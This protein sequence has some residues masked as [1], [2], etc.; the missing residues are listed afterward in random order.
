MFGR[1]DFYRWLE[2]VTA[3]ELMLWLTYLDMEAKGTLDYLPAE[4]LAQTFKNLWGSRADT[5]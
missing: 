1:A 3:E 5:N 2:E 4:D